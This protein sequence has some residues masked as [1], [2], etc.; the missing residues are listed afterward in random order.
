MSMRVSSVR[1]R[2]E[3]MRKTFEELLR[4]HRYLIIID[5]Y[6]LKASMLTEV[7][8]LQ[9][10]LNFIIKGGKKGI[11]L[12]AIENVYPES[13]KSLMNQ[14]EGQVLF[15]FTNADPFE[16]AIELDKFE[17]D[18]EASP[19]DLAP[20][21]IVIPEGNTGIPP[22]P[23]IGL[24]SSLNIPTKIVAGAIH[25]V[26]DTL[27][28]KKGDRITP[29]LANILS[30]LGIKPIKSKVNIVFAYDFKDNLLI[31]REYLIPNIEKIRDDIL[32]S[33][34]NAYK[35]VLEIA[36]IT[37]KTLPILLSKAFINAL[38]LSIETVYID[39]KT[40]PH[41]IRKAVISARKLKESVEYEH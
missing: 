21:D 4:S 24:F 20:T 27:V 11:F 10:K 29:N 13:L 33:S 32:A 9:D 28:A 19:G 18:L 36:Y 6:R 31:E 35:I 40:I 39:E 15:I 2:K 17:M 12:K 30:K 1:R 23:V 3:L 16:I 25:I 22:G 38:S 26:K 7:R 41:L 8:R 5:A 14:L 37:D 34:I